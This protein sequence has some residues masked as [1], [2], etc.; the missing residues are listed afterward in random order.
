MTHSS[1]EPPVLDRPETSAASTKKNRLALST[2]QKPSKPLDPDPS[3]N[4]DLDEE[5]H[6]SEAE[7]ERAAT[8]VKDEAKTVGEVRRKVEKMTYEEESGV[9]ESDMVQEVDLPD[10]DED[11]GPNSAMSMSTEI[12]APA[13]RELDERPRE[14]EEEKTDMEEWQTIDESEAVGAAETIN[15]DAMQTGG[16]PM[17]KEPSSSGAEGLKRKVGDRSESSYNIDKGDAQVK[18]QKDTPSVSQHPFPNVDH[19]NTADSPRVAIRRS[20]QSLAID[21]D[22][23]AKEANNFFSILIQRLAVCFC[24]IWL[25]LRYGRS[26]VFFRGCVGIHSS[27]S[28][29]LERFRKFQHLQPICKARWRF[30][31]VWQALSCSCIQTRGSRRTKG[32]I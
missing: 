30:K 4:I 5:P 3:P 20:S 9:K 24:S 14:E 31:S 22:R 19:A 13:S 2:G 17:G 21:R 7:P 26:V 32:E 8:S 25:A 15:T 16:L 1:Q 29:R 12:S 6:D 23:P 27:P 18:R 10:K 28:I 11:E